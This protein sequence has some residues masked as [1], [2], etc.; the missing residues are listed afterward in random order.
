MPV[1]FV[2]NWV[3]SKSRYV[4]D[5]EKYGAIIVYSCNPHHHSLENHGLK[6]PVFYGKGNA[7]FFLR[8]E[9]FLIEPKE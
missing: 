4:S 3:D 6:I 9:I 2:Q 5:E 8:P 1:D 7:G